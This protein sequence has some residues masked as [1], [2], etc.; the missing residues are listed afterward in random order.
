MEE[1]I[2]NESADGGAENSFG[3]SFDGFK[4]GSGESVA[5]DQRKYC[6][7]QITERVAVTGREDLMGGDDFNTLS[8]IFGEEW[9]TTNLQERLLPELPKRRGYPI[10]ALVYI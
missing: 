6:I 1:I 8:Y 9:T 10:R 3:T 4:N 7:W 2:G 5:A